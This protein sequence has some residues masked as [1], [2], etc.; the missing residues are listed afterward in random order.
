MII[1]ITGTIGAGKGTVVDYLVS[2]KG[3]SHFSSRAFFTKELERRGLPVNRDTMTPLANELRAA[4]G[5]AYVAEELLKMAEAKG[6]N[7]IVESIRHPAEAE[8]IRNYGG[9]IIAVDADR[10]IRYERISARK[11]A[12]DH[13]SYEEFVQ[14]EE[15]ELI[16]TDPH[17]QNILAV[18]EEAD[19]H[20]LNNGTVEELTVEL[21][22]LCKKLGIE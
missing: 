14:Q 5:P 18:I 7:A 8:L 10:P 6:G 11:S 20:I 17:S 21:D 4:H 2:Q 16:S 1:G 9:I 3:F 15:R 13:V 22:E 19:Y 12:L